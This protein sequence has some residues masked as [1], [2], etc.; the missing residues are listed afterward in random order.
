MLFRSSSRFGELVTRGRQ[1]TEFS[2][3]PQLHEG[4]INGGFFVFQKKFLDYLRADDACVLEGEPLERLVKD[5]Q[6]MVFEHK[7]F[8]QCMDTYRDYQQ[9]NHLWDAHEAKWKIW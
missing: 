3:K 9:L 5:G 8:W 7:G 1:V 2:E 4:L 6:L